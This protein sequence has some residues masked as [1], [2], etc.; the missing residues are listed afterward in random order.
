MTFEKQFMLMA[1][2][3]LRETFLLFS[4]CVF[5]ADNAPLFV[6]PEIAVILT[7]KKMKEQRFHQSH[8]FTLSD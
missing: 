6:F 8:F 1:S 7:T 2:I 4:I 5:I 3:K